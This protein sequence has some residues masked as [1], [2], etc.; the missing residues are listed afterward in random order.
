MLIHSVEQMAVSATLLSKWP[1]QCM[2]GCMCVRRMGRMY[3]RLEGCWRVCSVVSACVRTSVDTC[4]RMGKH[5]CDRDRVGD[6]R[7]TSV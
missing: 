5:T 7:L 6:I 2:I 1:Y 3:D 4:K